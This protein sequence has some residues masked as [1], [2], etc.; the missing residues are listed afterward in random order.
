MA[1]VRDSIIYLTGEIVSKAT[2][3]FLLPVLTRQLTQAEFANYALNYSFFIILACILCFYQT[4]SIGRYYFRYG[5]RGETALILSGVIVSC[6]ILMVFF[7][8]LF[9][10]NFLSLSNFWVLL[11]AFFNSL[12]TVQLRARQVRQ[13]AKAYIAAQISSSLVIL[14][15]TLYLLTLNLQ[16]LA[17][18]VAAA[19]VYLL[20]TFYLALDH[21]RRNLIYN[22]T[23][24]K[25]TV[26][27]V[28]YILTLGITGIIH[29]LCVISKGH[30]DRLFIGH[31]YKDEQLAIYASA[32][33]LASVL[34][35]LILAL[36]RGLTPHI[37]SLLKEKKIRKSFFLRW[38]V[39]SLTIVPIPALVSLL[40]PE[41][42]YQQILGT[43]YG[44]AKYYTTALLFSFGFAIPYTILISYLLYIGRNMA[45]G[46]ISVITTGMYTVFLIIITNLYSIQYVPY[47][48]LTVNIITTLS[49]WLYVYF[50]K[51]DRIT[52]IE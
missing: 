52:E 14:V 35:L 15:S 18:F 10:F 8:I 24:L 48:S 40:V 7:L 25:R 2:P 32:I 33:Q 1:K 13:Q 4:G 38:S 5:Q 51:N 47:A 21:Y 44:G 42:V 36:N 20:A 28:R 11:A 43:S 12:F 3:F 50:I 16:A 17:Y 6:V 29:Q 45:V 31:T 9:L 37:W 49:F 46:C 34:T 41:S 22:R 39:N 30:L 23:T 27:M 19:I 26:T